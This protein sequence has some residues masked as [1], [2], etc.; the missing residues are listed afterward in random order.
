MIEFGQPLALFSGIAI[1]MPVLAHMAYRTITEKRLFSSLRF[2]SPT[3]I[4]RSG[5]KRPSDWLLLLLRVLLF[6]MITGM[7]AD[8]HWL[9]SSSV[10]PVPISN[11]KR[12]HLID[13]SLSMSGWGAWD[14]AMTALRDQ[15]SDHTSG[16]GLLAWSD[17]GL[18]EWPCGS[19]LENLRKAVESLSPVHGPSKLNAML[20]RAKKIMDTEKTLGEI[21]VYSDFQ[22]SEWQE[23]QG[24]LGNSNTQIVLVPN[25]HGK[26]PW[27]DRVG[28]RAILEAKVMPG[29]KDRIRIWSVLG[30]WDLNATSVLVS[31]LAGGEIRQSQNVMLPPRGSE[32][33]QFNLPSSDFASATIRLEGSD[34]CAWDDN[35]SFWVTPPPAKEFAILAKQPLA[36]EDKAEVEFLE[37]VFE[38][39]GDG[40][41]NRW[42]LK[43]SDQ[44][45]ECLLIPGF[46]GWM[47]EGMELP[48]LK[49]H[50]ENGG[51]ALLTP[52]ESFVR[53]NQCL[54][55]YDLLNF[56]FHRLA[57]TDYR[58]DPYRIE[59]LPETSPLTRVFSGN[60]AL[61]LY[62]TQVRKFLVLR[63]WE[64]TAECPIYDRD[65]RPLAIVRKFPDGGRLVFLC[66]RLLPDWTDLPTRNS[67]LP[68]L[69]QL[70][71]LEEEGAGGER[72]TGL[73]PGDCLEDGDSSFTARLPG[74]FQ[75]MEH[76]LEV[77]PK[78]SE[79]MPEVISREE[80]LEA[81]SGSVGF[82]ITSPVPG[83]T[84]P[85][86]KRLSKPLWMWFALG[87]FV[88]LIIEMFLS[89][90]RSKP[91][92][93]N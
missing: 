36:V 74:L 84:T 26:R 39:V 34:A 31:V 29:G 79:S 18:I 38:S 91:Q 53:M 16:H 45:V 51:T 9:G 90:P 80:A 6:L 10:D 21:R 82:S 33:V 86:K 61:D 48:R 20:E 27:T 37:A 47:D 72:F 25:G 70:C 15:F 7:L 32:Q 89:Q 58:M 28:N 71:A 44:N 77:Y 52:G 14:E 50:L 5:R 8:P 75:W 55:D 24:K 78:L 56:T 23:V 22:S 69:V 11:D 62:L 40:V 87:C 83:F 93:L 81:L 41:W 30:N 13:C 67:F 19:S 57:Q 35:R 42:E 17:D 59:V 64:D 1:G 2:I 12:L 73:V 65:G 46:S 49:D 66:F 63:D 92:P 3:T 60:S 85:E 76:R 88:L 54:K 4:P 68:L 43:D